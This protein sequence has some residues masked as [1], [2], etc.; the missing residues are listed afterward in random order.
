M[1][2][3]NVVGFH[4]FEYARHFMT[5]CRRLLGLGA[6]VGVSP[7]GGVLSIKKGGGLVTLTVSHVGIDRDVMLHRLQ[8]P[9]LAA[10]I[11]KLR[12]RCNTAGRKVIGGVEMLNPLQGAA[13]KLDAYEALLSNYPMWRERV[14]LVQVCFADAARPDQ[15]RKYS[16]SMREAATRIR[17]RFGEGALYYFEVGAEIT[18]WTV[19]DRLALFRVCDVYLNCAMRDGLNLLPF[20]YVLCKSSQQPVAEGLVVLSEFVGCAHVLNGAMRI[21]PFNL[22]HIVEQLDLA[23]AM[24]PEERTARL[25]KDYDFVRSHSTSTWLKLA[26]QDMRRVRSAMLSSIPAS[27]PTTAI[28]G[29]PGGTCKGAPVPRLQDAAVVRAYRNSTRRVIFLGLDGT[30]IQQEQVITHLKNFHDF[31]GHSLQPPAAALQCLAQL[32]ADPANVVYVISGRTPADMQ[33]ILGQVPRL[34]LAAELGYVQRVSKEPLAPAKY[35]SSGLIPSRTGSAASSLSRSSHDDYAPIAALVHGPG[36]TVD[37][38][39]DGSVPSPSRYAASDWST[40]L[41]LLPVPAADWRERAQQLMCE[42][43]SRTNGSYVRAQLSGVQWCYHDADP[44]F[45]QLQARSLTLQLRQRLT[46]AGVSVAHHPAKGLVEVRLSGVNKGA[47]ADVLLMAADRQAPVDFLLC[48]GDDD[49]DEYMLSAT[50]ARAC[51]PGLRERLQGKL[52]TVTVGGTSRPT[53][54]AQYVASSSSQVISLLEA[55]RNVSTSPAMPTTTPAMPSPASAPRP[56]VRQ[57]NAGMSA[58]MS[59][60]HSP[61]PASPYMG[62]GHMAGGPLAGGF[63]GVSPHVAGMLPDGD[64]PLDLPS[65]MAAGGFGRSGRSAS[66]L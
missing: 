52:F 27:P 22:E 49:D 59:A 66:V 65:S 26:V 37:A 14:C 47:A 53:S 6:N 35:V 25:A 29:W 33:A 12:E 55:L 36:V 28:A 57:T 31:Q 19:N 9:E 4:L 50:T 48:I 61:T 41:H 21:N 3:A 54:H 8:Q 34:G 5:S 64:A 24:S 15:S 32:A 58:G 17:T 30:L 7:A 10:A 13:L 18:S 39:L 44:D 40:L 2:A 11:A 63:A 51:S 20:E 60:G 38:E 62:G 23:L 42:Y 46:D 43:T 56:F 45:G 1:L 16:A